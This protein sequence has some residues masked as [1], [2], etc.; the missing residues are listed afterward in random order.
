MTLPKAPKDSSFSDHKIRSF[1]MGYEEPIK[2]ERPTTFCTKQPASEPA[3]NIRGVVL[4]HTGGSSPVRCHENGS[5][6]YL[7]DRDGTLY[8]DVELKDIAWHVASTN[9]W[10]PDWVAHTAPWSSGSSINTCTIGIELVSA[11]GATQITPEQI[12]CLQYVA[13]EIKEQFGNLW[14]IGHGQVQLDRRLTEPDNFPWDEL[15]E[16]LDPSNGRRWKY[17]EDLNVSDAEKKLIEAVRELGFIDHAESVIRVVAGLGANESSIE[18]W[19]NEIGALKAQLEE[20]QKT[21]EQA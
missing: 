21:Q 13:H 10:K 5:W 14:W 19:I 6:H 18:G 4:H 9:R 17:E 15:C 12:S 16:P 7:I 2:I 8:C 20:A 11:A 1:F 3:R